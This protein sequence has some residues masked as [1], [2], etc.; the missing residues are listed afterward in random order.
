MPER[1]DCKW[2]KKGGEQC[3]RKVARTNPDYCG[4]HT[5]KAR[6]ATAANLKKRLAAAKLHPKNQ[7]RL[8][9]ICST[10]LIDSICPMPDVH[11]RILEYIKGRNPKEHKRLL[12]YIS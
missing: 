2:I 7:R 8:C 1:S 5:P 10:D 11:E 12:K 4:F 9:P 6:A 3:W